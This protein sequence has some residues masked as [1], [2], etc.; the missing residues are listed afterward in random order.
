MRVLIMD[1]E[2]AKTIQRAIDLARANT[3]KLQQPMPHTLRKRK[4]LE[5]K[6]R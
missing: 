5:K 4:R 6:K 1:D 2:Q 3:K